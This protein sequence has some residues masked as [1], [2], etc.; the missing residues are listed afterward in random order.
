[1][2][3]II[4]DACECLPEKDHAPGCWI[5]EPEEPTEPTSASVWGFTAVLLWVIAAAVILAVA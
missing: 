1:M 3:D 5:W 4:I 2:A